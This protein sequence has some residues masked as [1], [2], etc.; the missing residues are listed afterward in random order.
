M[1]IVLSPLVGLA[2][3][4]VF[5]L[6]IMWTFRRVRR[7]D[8]LNAS[9]RRGQLVSAAGFSLGHGE[10]DAQKMMGVILAVLIGSGTFQPAPTCPC[11]SCSRPMRPSGPGP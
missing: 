4:L 2:L 9:F 6:V 10:N 5:T 3:A 1:F 7:V 11:G 8:L